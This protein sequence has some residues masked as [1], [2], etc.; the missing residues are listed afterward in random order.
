MSRR[1]IAP[2]RV[3]ADGQLDAMGIG[4]GASGVVLG[5]DSAAKPV[6]VRLFGPEPMSVTFVGGWW[7]AQVLTYRCLAHGA[8]VVVDALDTAT[9]ADH[10]A[11]AGLSQWLSLDRATGG[12]GGRVRPMFGGPAPV[13][14]SSAIQPL[15]RLYDAGPGGPT[16]RLQLQAWQ[17]QLTVLSRVTAASL[18]AIS[19]ADLV[20]AQRLDPPEAALI[21]SA[22]LLGPD[23]IERFGAMDNEMVA[24]FRGPAVRYAWLNP[25]ALERQ[26]FG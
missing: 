7:A 16:G 25:T 22:L 9:P 17:T 21:G 12:V 11:M 3:P 6:L 5:R 14:P 19:G 15:L 23:F 1:T 26:I 18:P 8:V 4:V 24:A 2:A 20:L 10:G 13:W